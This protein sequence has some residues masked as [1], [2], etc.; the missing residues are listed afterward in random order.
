MK[1]RN[2]II[3]LVML[4]LI[5]VCFTSTVNG[6]ILRKGIRD[7]LSGKSF[8]MNI[9][10][11]DLERVCKH[12]NGH[13]MESAENP[14]KCADLS[15][16]FSRAREQLRVM[17]IA[18]RDGSQLALSA[19]NFSQHNFGKYRIWVASISYLQTIS[20]PDDPIATNIISIAIPLD[21]VTVFVDTTP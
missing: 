12:K 7:E 17:N 11:N 20:N 8:Q 15:K 18:N 1:I 16:I 6:E 21:D 19:L 14:E 4:K 10:L 9:R 13:L 2:Y 3:N 5:V